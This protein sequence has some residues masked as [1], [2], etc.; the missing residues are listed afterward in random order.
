MLRPTTYVVGLA[1]TT[2]QEFVNG[3]AY[4]ADNPTER[5]DTIGSAH[6]EAASVLQPLVRRL[7]Q[8]SV[9]SK[10][11]EAIDAGVGVY[12]RSWDLPDSIEGREEA[13]SDR[14]LEWCRESL[15]RMRKP[16]GLD[17]VTLVLAVVGAENREIATLGF[18]VLRPQDF[19]GDADASAR[20]QEVIGRWWREGILVSPQA[21]KLS[22]VLFSWGDLTR[23]LLLAG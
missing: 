11:R 22:A 19:Y 18:G 13:L 10:V 8:A 20:L 6:R 3:C 2:E 21:L 9:R 23:E 16:Y 4:L 15:A 17:Y 12:D 7:R 1:C 14:I 5:R